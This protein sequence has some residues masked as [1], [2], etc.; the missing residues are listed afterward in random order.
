MSSGPAWTTVCALCAASQHDTCWVINQAR[1][2]LSS[3]HIC[4]IEVPQQPND[5]GTYHVANLGTGE[6]RGSELYSSIKPGLGPS[7]VDPELVPWSIPVIP[8]RG[9][10]MSPSLF[11]LAGFCWLSTRRDTSSEHILEWLLP[12]PHPMSPS[13][14]FYLSFRFCSTL[15][16]CACNTMG[17]Q[18]GHSVSLRKRELDVNCCCSASLAHSVFVNGCSP[19][20]HLFPV[21]FLVRKN[22][23]EQSLVAQG[24]QRLSVGAH[25]CLGYC[26]DGRGPHT[27]SSKYQVLNCHLKSLRV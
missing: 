19:A 17:W 14:A 15:E 13:I 20:S 27:W 7:H 4:L 25:L 10:E 1:N 2:S 6:I 8:G 12:L 9:P 24:Q 16:N 21:L 22:S 11:V 18:S 23:G 26:S 5:V 3:P